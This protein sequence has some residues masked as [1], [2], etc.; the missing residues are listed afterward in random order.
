[1]NITQHTDAQTFNL[2]VRDFLGCNAL[3]QHSMLAFCYLLLQ[4]PERFQLFPDLI[5]LEQDRDLVG[6]AMLLPG[7]SLFVSTVSQLEGVDRLA[8]DLKL[9]YGELSRL[10]AQ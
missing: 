2:R 5:T 10:N 4:R 3:L 8:H 9:R 1:M 6:V 7:P